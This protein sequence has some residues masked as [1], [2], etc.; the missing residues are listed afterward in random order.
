[1]QVDVAKDGAA[2]FR[3]GFADWIKAIVVIGACFYG[4]AKMQCSKI[5]TVADS[6]QTV[7][8]R[9]TSVERGLLDAERATAELKADYKEKT[10]NL[11]RYEPDQSA[12]SW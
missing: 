1:M 10:Y 12:V 8:T 5:D 4:H 9:L 3:I 11:L 6:L 7:S 2:V